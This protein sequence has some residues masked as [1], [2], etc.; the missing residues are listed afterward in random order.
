MARKWDQIA[1]GEDLG[2]PRD[3]FPSALTGDPELGA[4]D[5]AYRLAGGLK[6][7]GDMVAGAVALVAL[8]QF[9]FAVVAL[10][11]SMASTF[12]KAVMF[13]SAALEFAGA[14]ALRLL[15]HGVGAVVRATADTAGSNAEIVTLLRTGAT[16]ST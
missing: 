8:A 7:M 14:M 16:R 6:S 2:G 11:G 9:V 13:G 12:F 3:S 15:L 10:D 4:Y 1:D 5:D